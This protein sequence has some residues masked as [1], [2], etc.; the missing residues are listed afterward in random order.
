MDK[1]LLQFKIEAAKRKAKSAI[2][3]GVEISKAGLEYV[4]ENK[5]VIIPVAM[6]VMAIA[7]RWHIVIKFKRRGKIDLLASTIAGA[8]GTHALCGYREVAGRLRSGGGASPENHADRFSQAWD[9]LHDI[10]GD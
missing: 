4:S 1:T 8:A 7:R 5:E 6:G 3:K 10:L 2:G 9:W